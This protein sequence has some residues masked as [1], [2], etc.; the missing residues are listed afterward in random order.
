MK[1]FII[2]GGEGTRMRPLSLHRP[3]HMIPI[4]N[5]PIS[6]YQIECL[7]RAGVTDVILCTNRMPGDTQWAADAAQA[8]G[9][10]LTYSLEDAPL[11]TGGALANAGAGT[12]TEPF[13][14]LNGD[15]LM[16]FDLRSVLEA[17]SRSA[18]LATIGALRMDD[19]GPYGVLDLDADGRIQGFLEPSAADKTADPATRKVGAGRI[20]VGAYVMDPAALARVPLGSRYSLERQLFPELAAEGALRACEV[21]G[22][23]LD[24]GR[25]SDVPEASWA[26]L[27]GRVGG[28]VAGDQVR[29]GIW[30]MMGAD[31]ARG[32]DLGP[33]VHIGP[34]AVIAE[35]A[36][37]GPYTC[38]G[39]RSE[40]AAGAAVEYS[41]LFEECRVGARAFVAGVV[42]DRGTQFGEDVRVSGPRVFGERAKITAEGVS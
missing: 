17:H 21:E 34:E 15:A 32:A 3:K 42:A 29:P 35:G 1:G 24:V 4:A 6:E 7:V 37:V 11:D 39:A 12:G 38:L 30:V 5:R 25:P 26:V 13:F 14:A 20:N 10:R 16:D 8:L 9:A 23:W 41:V 18:A 27:E 2:A 28:R 33:P 31:I 36:R 19:T 40:V 22:F